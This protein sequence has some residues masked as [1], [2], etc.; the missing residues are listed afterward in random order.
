MEATQILNWLETMYP[1]TLPLER[2]DDFELGILVG[3]RQL[4]EQLKIKLQVEKP[5]QEEV[6]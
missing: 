2:V 6:K 5:K 4:I 3:Q 1:N